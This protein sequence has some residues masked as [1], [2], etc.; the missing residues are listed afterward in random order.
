M[1]SFLINNELPTI[2]KLLQA[3]NEDEDLPNFRRTTFYKL[4]K[5]LNFEHE[6]RSRHSLL[7]EIEEIILWGRQYLENIKAYRQEGYKI[8]YTDET[9]INARHTTTKVWKDKTLQSA[10]QVFLSGLSAGNKNPSGKGKRII[11]THIGS[12]NGLVENCGW[13][14]ESNKSGDYHKEMNSKSFEAWFGKTLKYLE[15]G[16][17]IILDNAPYHSCKIEKIPT[18]SWPKQKIKDWLQS[19]DINLNE[20]MLKLQLLDL[21]KKHR[22]QFE[23]FIID[24][25]A[26]K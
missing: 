24:E 4:L 6:R 10:K 13:V 11:V 3:V 17:V 20:S 18:S 23:G 22:S 19:K 16:A 1:H 9:W 7:I 2:D 12:E 8:Y 21:V 15:G 25:T 5:S 26:K 14:F